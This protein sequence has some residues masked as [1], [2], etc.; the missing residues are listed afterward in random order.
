METKTGM[1]RS[2]AKDAVGILTEPN[3][4]FQNR[5][6][7]LS[8]NQ[9]LAMGLATSWLAAMLEWLTRAVK[10]ESLLEGFRQIQQQLKDLPLWKDLPDDI[11]AQSGNGMETFFP[12]W[13]LE[14]MKVML[15]PFHA[16]FSIYFS[17]F[18]FW[19]AA[20]I[21]VQR[22]NPTRSS[23]TIKEFSKITAV[24]ASTSLISAIL[25]FLPL[26][27]G[28]F[29]GWIYHIALLT[30]GF[31]SRYQI[32]RLRSVCLVFLPSFAMVA[33][34]ALLFLLVFGLIAIIVSSLF[35]G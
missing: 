24:A 33:F 11:W 35:H 6:P 31:S 1:V 29:I 17:A 20:L 32:S 9:A 28:N 2:L 10:K 16:V 3:E 5:F 23:V 30:I 21:L 18:L 26:G 15:T 14:G 8:F 12:G 19:A 4:F 22:S 25:G 13:I 7:Q 27:I 34:L